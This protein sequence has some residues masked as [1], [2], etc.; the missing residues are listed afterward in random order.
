M[1]SPLFI[2]ANS[3]SSFTNSRSP[4]TNSLTPHRKLFATEKPHNLSLS[5]IKLTTEAIS[6]QSQ[7]SAISFQPQVLHHGDYQQQ[8]QLDFSTEP[9]MAPKSSHHQLASIHQQVHPISKPNHNLP[10]PSTLT[11][12]C[13]N[14]DLSS[15][16]ASPSYCSLDHLQ[17]EEASLSIT[18]SIRNHRPDLG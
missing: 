5:S 6:F 15:T 4:K 10:Q 17:S 16:P 2:S 14:P 13:N 9:N 11:Y 3:L 18:K 7:V 8:L 1:I 12:N